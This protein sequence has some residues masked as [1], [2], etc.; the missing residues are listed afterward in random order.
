MP[1]AL[2]FKLSSEAGSSKLANWLL[3]LKRTLSLT[4]K[5]AA[6]PI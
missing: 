4:E 6:S 2:F 3:D 1:S 5:A